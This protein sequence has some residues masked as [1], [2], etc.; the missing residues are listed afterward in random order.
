MLPCI[1]IGLD[2]TDLGACTTVVWDYCPKP[3]CEL[4]DGRGRRGHP[5]RFMGQLRDLCLQHALW[6]HSNRNFN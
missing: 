2:G 3:G 6:R 5:E 4:V 1:D